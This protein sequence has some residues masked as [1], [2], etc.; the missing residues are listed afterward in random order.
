MSKYTNA[1]GQVAVLISP[2]FG[3][4]WS[5]NNWEHQEFLAMDKGLVLLALSKA[6]Y[7]EVSECCETVIPDGY[8]SRSAW[9]EIEVVFL[10]PGEKFQVHE[11]DGHESIRILS[12]MKFMEA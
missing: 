1:Q 6:S 7:D 4:G 5:S 12:K 11:Y 10:A 3:S 2:G 9:E 8:V